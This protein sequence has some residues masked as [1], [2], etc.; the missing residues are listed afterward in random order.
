MAR[1]VNFK[2]AFISRTLGNSTNFPR[3]MKILVKLIERYPEETFWNSLTIKFKI[4]SLAYFLTDKGAEL[5]R[6]EY[7]KFKFQPDEKI[8]YE[9]EETV[10]IPVQNPI[11]KNDTPH[12]AKS[13]NEFL[14]IWRK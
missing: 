8:S 4:P 6:L 14:K 1:K 3:E 13:L 9:I 10:E 5:I 12:R 11:I 7:G 2:Q